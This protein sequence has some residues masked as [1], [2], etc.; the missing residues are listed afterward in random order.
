MTDGRVPL[1]EFDDI[2]APQPIAELPPTILLLTPQCGRG[3]TRRP[4]HPTRSPG[5]RQVTRAADAGWRRWPCHRRD[6][7]RV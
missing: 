7:S 2:I 1:Y 5:C 6:A 4:L 3:A